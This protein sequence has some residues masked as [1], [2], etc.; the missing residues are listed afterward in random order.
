[1][2]AGKTPWI[3][4][5]NHGYTWGIMDIHGESWIHMGNH[6]YTWRIMDTY[7]ESWIHMENHGYIWGGTARRTM[8][9]N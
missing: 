2:V 8:D 4:M 3:H 7:G 1:M 5:G 6:G 9:F